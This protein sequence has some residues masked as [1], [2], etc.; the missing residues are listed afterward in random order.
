MKVSL[1]QMWGGPVEILV[2][3]LFIVLGPNIA[4]VSH[5]ESYIDH[6]AENLNESYDS[7]N[8]FNIFEH[9]L[10]LRRKK[11][12]KWFTLHNNIQIESL[13]IWIILQLL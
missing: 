11:D 6:T 4:V 10:K 3:D 13:I 1:L 8:M 5:D 2:E 9:Q 7:S 12:R